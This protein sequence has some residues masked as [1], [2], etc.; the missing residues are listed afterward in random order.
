[1]LLSYFLSRVLLVRLLQRSVHDL[2]LRLCQQILVTPLPQIEAV[3]TS[4]LFTV[5]TEDITAI[6]GTLA[7]LPSICINVVIIVGSLIYLVYLSPALLAF[8]IVLLLLA[9]ISYTTLDTR[10]AH[11]LRMAREE[12]DRL[13]EDFDGLISGNRELKL[14][15]PRR[16]VFVVGH[17]TPHLATVRDTSIRGGTLYALALS[18]GQSLTVLLIGMVLFVVPHFHA[19]ESHI[20]SGYAL[21]V[22]QL[23]GAI[24]AL[25]EAIPAWRRA[26]IS[27]DKVE[28]LRIDLD[29]DDL[30]T[31]PAGEPSRGWSRLELVGVTYTFVREGDGAFTLGPID[32]GFRP[33]EIVFITGGNGSGKTTLAKLIAGLYAPTSGEIRLDGVLVREDSRDDYRQLFTLAFTDGHLFRPLLGLDEEGVREHLRRFELHPWVHVADGAFSTTAL[34][35]GQ[36]K[37]LMLATALVED[38][39]FYIFDEWTANQDPP[40]RERF[41]SELLPQLKARGKAVVVITHDDRYDHLADTVIRMDSGK[42]REEE[43]PHQSGMEMKS[44]LSP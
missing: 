16:Q 39:P 6:S 35:Q 15:R 32:L 19:V 13:S 36:R 23:T 44:C 12:W 38:R 2:R 24:G 10:A 29:A 8:L 9:I 34:S 18:W 28:Q 7:L 3:G 22:I 25:L 14:H 37:R 42:I 20:L 43:K 5:L 33:G 30:P 27:L 11:A 26:Q 21:G 17:L 40:F 41:Y 1:M 4:R 31:P